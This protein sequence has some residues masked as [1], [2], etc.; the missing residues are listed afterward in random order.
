MRRLRAIA[1][2]RRRIDLVQLGPF[3]LFMY[4]DDVAYQRLPA[5]ARSRSLHTPANTGNDAASDES[6][7]GV[8]AAVLSHYWS[9]GLDATYVDV[10][11]QY[12]ASAL[13][14]A[15][16]QRRAGRPVRTI[17]FEPGIARDLV[18]ANFALNGFAEEIV[19]EPSAVAAATSPIL[20]F[21][22]AST[23]ENNRIVNRRADTEA[24]SWV[25]PATSIDDYVERHRI[26]MPLVVKIDT[27]GAET[28]VLDG[29]KQVLR[30]RLVSC[31]MEFTP[32][33]LTDR[34]DPV[35]F[36][37]ELSRDL[38]VL[39][40]GTLSL[41]LTG[42]SAGA[43]QRIETGDAEAFVD[44]LFTQPVKWTDLLLLPRQLPR[45]D[46]LLAALGVPPSRTV[47]ASEQ[48][49]DTLVRRR[50]RLAEARSF[51]SGGALDRAVPL[52]REAV[53]EVPGSGELRYLLGFGLQWS[54]GDPR[55]A[56][57]EYCRAL[58]LGYDEFWVRF[59]RGLLLRTMGRVDEARADLR[60]ATEIEPSH[61]DARQ[62]LVDLEKA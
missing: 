37:L 6:G 34:F 20:M 38:V 56:L 45:L 29:M 17:A 55:D 14:V 25:V 22:E 62:A 53:S 59:Q 60:R 10:G 11:C 13:G 2:E 12:G 33:A 8:I 4:T 43:C 28:E 27:Q 57:T 26:A 9:N 48:E 31:V 47:P 15:A 54:G 58:E 23:T 1:L 52:L 32:W 46:S 24:C 50:R 18:P 30:D 51:L 5:N 49:F 61:R 40:I 39:D 21:G 36:L 3:R 41:N 19:F 16:F 35:L 42:A 7:H 44:R